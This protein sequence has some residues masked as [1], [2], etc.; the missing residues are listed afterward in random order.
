MTIYIDIDEE[1]S[2][3][4]EFENIKEFDYEDAI[5]K[6]I[7]KV[8]EFIKC[9]YDIEVNVMITDNECIRAI[10]SETREIDRATDV[11][12]FPYVEYNEPGDFSEIDEEIEQLFN[13]NTNELLLGDIVLSTD[14]VIEQANE[15]GHSVLRELSFLVIHSMLHLFGYDH[16]EEDGDTMEKLQEKILCE[17]NITRD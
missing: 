17:M 8:H 12:S 3:N 15:Y 9:P 2:I 1:A 13:P 10:N 4:E 6:A 5:K 11:L 16:M 7:K 14:R